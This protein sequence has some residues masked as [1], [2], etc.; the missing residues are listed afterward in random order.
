MSKTRVSHFGAFD[1]I[2]KE[3]IQ[4]LTQHSNLKS[5][6]KAEIEQI[7]YGDAVHEYRAAYKDIAS[8][9][10]ATF[11]SNEAQQYN[12]EQFYQIVLYSFS[13]IQPIVEKAFGVNHGFLNTIFFSFINKINNRAKLLEP[14]FIQIDNAGLEAKFNKIKELKGLPQ[15]LSP[16]QNAIIGKAT[17]EA[18]FGKADEIIKKIHKENKTQLEEFTIKHKEFYNEIMQLAPRMPAVV[19]SVSQENDSLRRK[20]ETKK[21]CCNSK[22]L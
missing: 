16:E 11:P 22:H 8:K 4:D 2:F 6:V 9:I 10:L 15:N 20:E 13:K 12:T 7:I 1:D 18:A 5:N 21:A 19:N 14:Y 3:L 17:V